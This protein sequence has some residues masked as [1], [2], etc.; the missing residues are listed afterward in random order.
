MGRCLQGG[1]IC[2]WDP[3]LTLAQGVTGGG[4]WGPCL[5]F[6]AGAASGPVGTS[7]A[8]LSG[9][10]RA[11]RCPEPHVLPSSLLRTQ[12]AVRMTPSGVL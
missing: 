8:F 2:G 10:G 4:S 11:A 12:F 7:T 5:R 9:V 6:Q 1:S 3:G